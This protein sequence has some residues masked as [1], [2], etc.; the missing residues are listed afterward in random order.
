M[1]VKFSKL[2]K[3]KLMALEM[4]FWRKTAR[5]STRE[6]VRNEIEKMDINIQ[7]LMTIY[8]NS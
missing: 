1:G 8:Q 6:K 5:I 3:K 4:D 7:F 2:K